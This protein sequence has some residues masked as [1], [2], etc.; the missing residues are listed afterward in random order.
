MANVATP[1]RR[2]VNAISASPSLKAKGTRN[3]GGSE[4]VRTR[5][6]KAEQQR[7]RSV[8]KT[9][10]FVFFFFSERLLMVDRLIKCITK[11]RM[12]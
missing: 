4:N 1:Q 10:V 3:R 11:S 9:L 12:F 2:D 8:E 7:T 5:A 6:W